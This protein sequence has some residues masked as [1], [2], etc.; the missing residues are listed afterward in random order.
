MNECYTLTCNSDASQNASSSSLILFNLHPALRGCYHSALYFSS[1]RCRS[2]IR[3]SFCC[4]CA[5][6]LIISLSHQDMLIWCL[7]R[8]SALGVLVNCTG[9]IEAARYMDCSC[10]LAKG[11]HHR[12]K[13]VYVVS[14]SLQ[15]ARQFDHMT[16]VLWGLCMPHIITIK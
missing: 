15:V 6:N 3:A 1:H 10:I 2:N 12:F 11:N 16:G 13:I 5:Y 4:L 8:Q 9:M 14:M 7:Q